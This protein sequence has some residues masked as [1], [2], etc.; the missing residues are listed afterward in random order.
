M[1]YKLYTEVCLC[2]FV[3]WAVVLC[4]IENVT[5]Q[6]LSFFFVL[7]LFLLL[8]PV[9]LWYFIGKSHKAQAHMYVCPHV[10]VF[11]AVVL[12]CVAFQLNSYPRLREETERIVTTHVREREGKTKDQVSWMRFSFIKWTDFTL[13]ITFLRYYVDTIN[14]WFIRAIVFLPTLLIRVL[15]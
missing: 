5:W 10:S 7:Y 15:N 14:V 1:V 6:S 2:V 3:C 11:S 4:D 9:S 12:C 8:I 13:I